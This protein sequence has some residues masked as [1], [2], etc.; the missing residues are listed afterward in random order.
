MFLAS[1]LSMKFEHV[2]ENPFKKKTLR[3]SKISTGKS[4]IP[5]F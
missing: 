3:R 4:P 1:D 5:R 2:P